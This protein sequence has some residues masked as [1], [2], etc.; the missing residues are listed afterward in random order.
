MGLQPVL[1]TTP[2]E[3]AGWCARDGFVSSS[4]CSLLLV[5]DDPSALH[6]LTHLLQPDF[7][8]LTA[9]SAEAARQ[10]FQQRDVDLS[11]E[12]LLAR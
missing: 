9:G 7:E 11:L 6:S 2:P 3:S 5:D 8:V 12:R 10:I 4:K 1:L